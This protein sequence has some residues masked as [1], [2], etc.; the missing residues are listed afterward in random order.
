MGNL[1][2]L[3][4]ILL[5]KY[6]NNLAKQFERHS[7]IKI[8]TNLIGDMAKANEYFRLQIGSMDVDTS[9]V[10]EYLSNER[11]AGEWLKNFEKGVVPFLLN[12]KLPG[13]E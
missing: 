4:L 9:E 13:W 12:N 2:N 5:A 3:I 1:H 8:S 11:N 10:R 6:D 7:P